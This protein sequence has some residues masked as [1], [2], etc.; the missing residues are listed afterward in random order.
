MGTQRRAFRNREGHTGKGVATPRETERTSVYAALH[1]RGPQV[2]GGKQSDG[3]VTFLLVGET[4]CQL[5]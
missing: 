3:V 5:G 4:S 1:S 2:P